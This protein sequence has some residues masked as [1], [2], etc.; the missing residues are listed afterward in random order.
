[1]NTPA[2]FIDK[3]GTLVDDVPYNVDPRRITL[4]AG[5]QEGLAALVAAGLRH[6]QPASERCG[7]K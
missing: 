5:A 3:D 6:L 4:A 7:Q 1:M 2:V